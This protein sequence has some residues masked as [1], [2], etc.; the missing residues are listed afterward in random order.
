M[1]KYLSLSFALMLGM[2]VF[3][4]KTKTSKANPDTKAKNAKT[5][6][7]AIIA[8]NPQS[9]ASGISVVIT[10]QIFKTSEKNIILSQFLGNGQFRD[11]GV[12]STSQA[13]NGKFL[14]KA[15]VPAG[16]FY[17]LRNGSQN[18]NLIV[19]NSDTIKIYGDG[20]DLLRNVN[21]VGNDDSQNLLEFM[22]YMTEIN[23]LRDSVQREATLNPAKQADLSQLYQ[24]RYSQFE[25]QRDNFIREFPNSP[26][27]IGPLQTLNPETDYEKF[28]S[29]AERVIAAVPNGTVAQ[30]LRQNLEQNR[31]KAE[32]ALFLAPG[33]EAPDLVGPSPEGKEY[34]LSDLRGKVVLI[35]FW[36]SWCGPCRKENP[37]VVAMYDKYKES[38]FTVF[39]VSLDSSKDAWVLAIQKDNLKWP[40]HI[41]DLQ[42]WNSAI[43]RIYGVSSIPFTVLLDAEGRVIR[44]NPRGHELG[45]ELYKI[46]GF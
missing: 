21:I 8:E 35:D 19:T 23:M 46:F 10:G 2:V 30:S 24:Q 3:A 25:F 45:Q 40:Y 17:V 31:L 34:K 43:S 27:L 28:K 37:N 16:D 12:D 18:I 15:T 44:K 38:G 6:E 7:K 32:A 9:N 11:F 22:R 29:L 20:R 1:K 13:K 5:D 41:S 4:Q 36:A 39:S 33:S 42:K 14:I 26:A